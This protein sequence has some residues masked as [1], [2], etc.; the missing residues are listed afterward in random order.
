MNKKIVVGG[1][2][3]AILSALG[4]Y[5][6]G[7]QAADNS[8]LDTPPAI[9]E[10]APVDPNAPAVDPAAVPVDPAAEEEDSW[11]DWYV[12]LWGPGKTDDN[13]GEIVR[14]SLGGH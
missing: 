11:Y 12:N 9:T 1:T 10:A 2:L 6:V 14:K 8:A 13:P 4:L 3:A 7:K 5:T